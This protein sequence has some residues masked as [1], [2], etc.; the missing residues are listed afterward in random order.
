MN[1]RV[2]ILLQS[3]DLAKH[4]AE[5]DEVVAMWTKA[6]QSL[7][8]SERGLDPPVEFTVAYQAAFQAGTAVLFACGYRA[9]GRDHH[10][11]TFAAAKAVGDP[12]MSRAAD[13][14]DNLRLDRN[15]AFYGTEL[16]VP[17]E[18]LV[19]LRSAVRQLM[20]SGYARICADRPGLA[21]R[22]VPPA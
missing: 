10:H 18:R 16:T 9:I 14:L 6:L 7:H 19:A 8:N 2:E 3:R 13:T 21:A 17:D 1:P 4:E 11:N 12:E 20:A 15:E 22:L 5:D